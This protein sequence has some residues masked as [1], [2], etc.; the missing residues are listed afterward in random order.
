MSS[1]V[2]MQND[3]A[4]FRKAVMTNNKESIERHLSHMKNVSEADLNDALFTCI[5]NFRIDEQTDECL[6]LLLR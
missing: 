5:E 2:Y 4:A 6:F 1:P 3:L